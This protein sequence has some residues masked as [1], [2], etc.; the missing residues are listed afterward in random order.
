MFLKEH[1]SD[2]AAGSKGQ[3]SRCLAFGSDLAEV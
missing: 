3:P 1:F 2:F